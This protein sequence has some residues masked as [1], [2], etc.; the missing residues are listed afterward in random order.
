MKLT[1]SFTDGHFILIHLHESMK[2]WASH[3]QQISNKYHYSLNSELSALYNG[4]FENKDSDRIKLVYGILLET[5]NTIEDDRLKEISLPTEFTHDQNLLN[6]LHRYYTD[7]AKVVDQNSELF[8]NVSKI[9]YCVH[10]LESYTINRYAGTGYHS[11]LWFHVRENPVPIDCW[12]N[13]EEHEK[14]NYNFFNYDY[15]YT[16]RLDRSILGKCVLQCFEENDDP[17]AKDCTGR[18]GSYGGFFI[19]TDNNLRE[20]Y[21]SDKFVSWC[22]SHGNEVKEM[23]LEFVIGNVERFSDEPKNYV[24]KT[25]SKINFD[26]VST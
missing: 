11:H 19:D 25:L 18:L 5:V 15:K 23:P 16:V 2:K 1:I 22:K 17:N 13:L 6:K 7:N 20:L 26:L 24:H 12:V 21:Q 14:E 10:E 3:V 9:N 4:K 8:R